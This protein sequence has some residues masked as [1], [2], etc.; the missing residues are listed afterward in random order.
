M[1]SC[2]VASMA[3]ICGYYFIQDNS[4]V[5]K[6]MMRSAFEIRPIIDSCKGILGKGNKKQRMA[7]KLAIIVYTLLLFINQGKDCFGR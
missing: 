6:I 1:I 4:E 5:S 7:V 3:A 2:A